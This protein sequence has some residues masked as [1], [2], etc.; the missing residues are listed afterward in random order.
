LPVFRRIILLRK[1]AFPQTIP[2]HKI[3]DI[4]KYKSDAEY[5]LGV[6]HTGVVLQA[7]EYREIKRAIVVS[8]FFI[9]FVF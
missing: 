5:K 3:M 6:P 2:Y 1:R 4:Q 8:N 9:Y 7:K